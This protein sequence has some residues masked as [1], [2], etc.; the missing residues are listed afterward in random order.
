MRDL[1]LASVFVALLALAVA[2]PFV[3]VLVW[4]WISFMNPH[5]ESWGFVQ[6]IPWAMTT[7][8]VTVFGCIVAGEPRRFPRSAAVVTILVFGVWITIT[9]LAG[10]GAPDLRWSMWE[11]TIK[12]IAGLL[13]TAAMLT[14]R[15][16]I[17]A[18]VWLIAISLGFYGVKGGIF[19]VVTGGVH[20]VL[21]PPSSMIADRNH[22]AV[23]LLVVLPLM[24][25]LR[26]QARH[27]IVRIVLVFAMVTTLI[28]AVGSQSRGALVALAATAGMF[29]L[30][31]QG[32]ILSGVAIVIAVAGVLA[33]MPDTW[34]ERMNTMRNY[35][36]D[37]SA[38]GRINIWIAAFSLGLARPLLGGGF[39]AIYSQ[40]IVDMVAP[41]V[42][43]R[44]THSIWFEVIADHGFPGFAIWLGIIC[45]GAWY[46]LR[47]ARLAKGRP[48]F[49]WAYDLARMSQVSAVAYLSGGSFLS[50]SY[51][52]FFWT[53]LVVLGAT[54]GLVTAAEGQPARAG[55]VVAQGWRSQ[56]VAGLRPAA[57]RA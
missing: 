14:E 6:T 51:W 33:F 32:K 21:G 23:A 53:L 34:V 15:R 7:F 27:R 56:P 12:V 40:P 20:I 49:R 45:A 22:L 42:Q 43:A 54:H 10:L 25:Y 35:E 13:L 28:A 37:G 16:R 36:A 30:R 29:W 24:N 9:T 47:I 44:A 8:L 52:D 48:E 41:G 55:R 2:R 11:K 17:D 4:S 5:R 57:D 18:M 3:G 19:T 26:L 50:L 46:S 1:A 31:S 39:Q 38:M